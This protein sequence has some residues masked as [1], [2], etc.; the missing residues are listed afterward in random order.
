MTEAQSTAGDRRTLSTGLPARRWRGLAGA[1]MLSLL[2]ACGGG[3][4]DPPP[5]LRPPS[6][7]T[8]RVSPSTGSI[9]TGRTLQLSANTLDAVGAGLTGRTITWTSQQPAVATVSATGLVTGVAAGTATITATADGVSGTATIGVLLPVAAR[10][11][12]TQPITVGQTLNGSILSTD[13]KLADDSYAD[14]YELTLAE[15]TPV[16]VQ[17]ASA[18]LD[19]YLIIQD[20]TTGFIVAENDDGTG[21]TDARIE[22][23]LP[24][25]RY[26]IVAN[27]FEA[28]DFGDY[29][30]S[31]SRASA[32]CL[33]SIPITTP[34]TFTGILTAS[35]CVLGDSSYTDRYLLTVGS[36]TVLTT[37]MRS[38]SVDSY[39][40][41][42]STAGVSIAR[43]DN[44][45]GATDARAVAA[46]APGSYIIYANSAGPRDTG[47]Y[48]LTLDSRIDPCGTSRVVTVGTTVTD[49]IATSSC[50]LSDGSYVR[51]YSLTVSA[52][53]AIRL[54]L[55]STRFDP[56]LIVQAAGSATTLVEDDDGGD[57]L[58]SQILQVF[59]PGEYV[60]TVTS[61][62][63]GELGA[64]TLALSGATQ[65][66]VGVAVTPTATTLT[67][68][69][70]QQLT[71]SVTGTTNSGV[72]WRSD[73]PASPRSVR[74]ASCA[75][76]PPAARPS[77]RRPP[78][79]HRRPRAPT[80]P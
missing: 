8:V 70:T 2:G 22:Q 4:D 18:A 62:T 60:I 1:A 54:D 50:R 72:A 13:C 42:E 58:D 68:G 38:D 27:T 14:K 78:P 77:R 26:V 73:S 80:S 45:A 46:L 56:Y 24:A 12:A 29:Q 28:N 37:T 39:L 19:A 40:F 59:D 11:D 32:T 64:F 55:L 67:P 5:S 44:G 33:A 49:T 31:V 3:S 36:A 34:G 43:N 35:D 9:E 48:T 10:C 61:A 75:P 63:S 6:V 53:T 74:R 57:G 66:V 47:P 23:E 30:L 25:G 21:S 16:R 69:L 41:I 76:S 15:A 20:A 71:A 7:V 79:T 65:S 52:P 17:M 51:R